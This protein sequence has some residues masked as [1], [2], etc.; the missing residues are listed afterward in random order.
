MPFT[1]TINETEAPGPMHAQDGFEQR[2]LTVGHRC[3]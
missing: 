1:L 3:G 2:W